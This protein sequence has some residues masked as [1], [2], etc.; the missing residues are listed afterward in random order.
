[1]LLH[2]GPLVGLSCLYMLRRVLCVLQP[3]CKQVDRLACTTEPS[4]PVHVSQGWRDRYLSALAIITVDAFVP[5]QQVSV[6]A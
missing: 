4:K 5:S 3:T 1:M 2:V 6:T